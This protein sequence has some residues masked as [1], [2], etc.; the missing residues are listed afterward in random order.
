[1]EQR[2]ESAQQSAV[3]HGIGKLSSG[4]RM[5]VVGLTRITSNDIKNSSKSTWR[6]LPDLSWDMPRGDFDANQWDGRSFPYRRGWK[7]SSGDAVDLGGFALRTARDAMGQN[8]G[9]GNPQPG[10][11]RRKRT[12]RPTQPCRGWWSCQLYSSQARSSPS[13]C[14]M[15]PKTTKLRSSRTTHQQHRRPQ[16]ASANTLLISRRWPW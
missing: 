4:T 10:R 7:L 16:A 3:G 11:V 6:F 14:A 12:G 8:A 9:Q 1:V 2:H 15:S 13:R 5:A